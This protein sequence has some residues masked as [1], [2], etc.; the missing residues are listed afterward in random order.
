MKTQS[1]LFT[2]LFIGFTL[3]IVSLIS[4][5]I[6]LLGVSELIIIPTSFILIRNNFSLNK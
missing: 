1:K 6:Y 5:S 3:C 4:K 2:I